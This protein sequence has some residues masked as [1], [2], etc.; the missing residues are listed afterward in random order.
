MELQALQERV[1]ERE[2]E[3]EGKE[4]EQERDIERQAHGEKLP[5]EVDGKPLLVL[6]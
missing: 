6:F 4:E 3:E 1:S 5:L 2:M